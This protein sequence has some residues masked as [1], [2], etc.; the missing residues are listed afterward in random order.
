MPK[1]IEKKVLLT[2]TLG[3]WLDN[4]KVMNLLGN[5]HLNEIIKEIAK[6]KNY[7][8]EEA[9][10][11]FPSELPALLLDNKLITKEELKKRTEHMVFFVEQAEKETYYTGKDSQEI[12]DALEKA[13]NL[14]KVKQIKGTVASKGNQK[15]VKGIARIVLDPS[16]NEFQKGEIL[17][18]SMTRPEYVPLMKKA[19]AV[20]TDEGGITSH[21]AII[22]RE[23][24]IPCVIGAKVATKIIKD[25]NMIEIDTEKGTIK[26]I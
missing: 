24:G 5:H 3:I 23:L 14:D 1:K 10:Y 26:I 25:K 22:S 20:V 6:R 4:R 21:A 9:Y 18:A 11:L 8:L 2:Q 17:I 15:S 13:R 19:L 12:L 16:K 7:S